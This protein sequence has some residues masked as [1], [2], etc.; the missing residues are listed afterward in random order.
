MH[1]LL[2]SPNIAPSSSADRSIARWRAPTTCMK[3]PATL[4]EGSPLAP[5][6]IEGSD[7]SLALQEAEVSLAVLTPHGIETETR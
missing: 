2:V 4:N 6:W 1:T 3:L 5:R 7:F